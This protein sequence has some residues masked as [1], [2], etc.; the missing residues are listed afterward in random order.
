MPKLIYQGRSIDKN[1]NRVGYLRTPD[2]M[3][4]SVYDDGTVAITTIG[5]LHVDCTGVPGTP[6][7]LVEKLVSLGFTKI[8][9]EIGT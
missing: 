8:E 3:E 9:E 5:K 6:G 4:V 2:Q 1:L 7:E